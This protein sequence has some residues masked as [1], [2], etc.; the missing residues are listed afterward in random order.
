MDI[1]PPVGAAAKPRRRRRAAQPPVG[2]SLPVPSPTGPAALS[3]VR[4]A[5]PG[6]AVGPAAANRP[7]VA[8]DGRRASALVSSSGQSSTEQPLT[9]TLNVEKK[10]QQIKMLE[11]IFRQTQMLDQQIELC[12]SGHL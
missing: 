7:R 9:L 4:P 3:L 12:F 10:T 6:H 11:I 5:A 1:K 8:A 2:R